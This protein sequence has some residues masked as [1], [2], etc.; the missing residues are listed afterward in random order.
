MRETPPDGHRPFRASLLLLILGLVLAT[1]LW[2]GAQ[3]VADAFAGLTVVAFGDQE[4][5]LLTG[6]T[7]LPD[8]GQIIDQESGVTLTAQ[9]LRYREG[10]FIEAEGVDLSGNFGKAKSN[11][12]HVDLAEGTL[13]ANGEVRFEREDFAL[14]AESLF[15]RPAAGV[16]RFGGPVEGSGIE[17]EAA[18][19]VLDTTTG[20]VLLA[21]PYRYED[22]LFELS[23]ERKGALLSL[24]PAPESPGS[25]VASS[26]VDPQ[27]LERLE[28]YLP[29]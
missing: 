17:F 22:A 29:Q 19:A 5:D 13:E 6:I 26:Q 23:S 14:D 9:M 2:A 20:T 12:I 27:L 3:D 15:Y 10:D 16:V 28:P 18:A 11:R 4:V 25:L 24:T 8:G 21:A 1:P 7:T